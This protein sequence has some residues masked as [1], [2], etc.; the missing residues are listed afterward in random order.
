MEIGN[1]RLLL[2]DHLLNGIITIKKKSPAKP[3]DKQSLLHPGGNGLKMWKRSSLLFLVT[4]VTAILCIDAHAQTRKIEEAEFRSMIRTASRL[5]AGLPMRVTVTTEGYAPGDRSRT[6]YDHGPD[7]AMRIAVSRT[8]KG[9]ETRSET[10]R[11][12]GSVYI[13]NN[14]G[15]WRK[16]EVSS[17]PG[18]GIGGVRGSGTGFGSSG[19]PPKIE[20]EYVYLGKH[21]IDGQKADRYRKTIKTTSSIAERKFVRTFV[22]E[23]WYRE[24][25]M[26]LR[27]VSED[28][29]P[30]NKYRT[31]TE[32]DYSSK[33]KIEPPID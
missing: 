27:M 7:G 30:P 28:T 9:V 33:I 11:I 8:S 23:Y 21:R 31:T 17:G 4:S 15:E 12:D 25:G 22:E 14:E 5:R 3:S 6:V 19:T 10:I 24:D 32:Y 18:S 1:S 20:I 13:R 26:L 16:M 2:S 29:M